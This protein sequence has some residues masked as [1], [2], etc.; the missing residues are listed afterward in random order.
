MQID[1]FRFC[2]LMHFFLPCQRTRQAFNLLL[3]QTDSHFTASPE[4][5]LELFERSSHYFQKK[6]LS[7]RSFRR[8]LRAAAQCPPPEYISFS[9]RQS[10]FWPPQMFFGVSKS[11]PH[12]EKNDIHAFLTHLATRPVRAG[13]SGKRNFCCMVRQHI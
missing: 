2:A 11:G 13:R 8:L 1:A 4:P 7:L 10:T 9:A 5:S 12:I 3:A 6:P